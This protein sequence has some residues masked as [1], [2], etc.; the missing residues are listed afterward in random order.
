MKRASAI[1]RLSD[2]ADDLE[3]SKEWPGSCVVAGYV[4]G[5]ML[6]PAG[7]VER[8]QLALVVDEPAEAAPWMS[9][10][11][12]LEA[13]ASLLGLDKL[14][15]SWQWLFRRIRARLGA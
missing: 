13:L 9:R 6:H 15:L 14:P 12:R 3:R 4:F 7:D 8:V 11:K 1:S 10:P 2:V 5:S